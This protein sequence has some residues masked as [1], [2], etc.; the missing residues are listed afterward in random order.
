MIKDIEFLDTEFKD[1]KDYLIQKTDRT[2]SELVIP[3]VGI[4]KAYNY[5]H[6]YRDPE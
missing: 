6:G 5:Y 4:K 2:I 3:K 1:E